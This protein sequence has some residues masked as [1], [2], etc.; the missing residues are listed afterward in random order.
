V[1][2]DKNNIE[3]IQL[4]LQK[5][6]P[7]LLV[8]ET[9]TK[10]T[11]ALQKI[12]KLNPQLVFL[13]IQLGKTNV[14]ELLQKIKLHALEVIFMGEPFPFLS[15]AFHFSGV[16][17]VETPIVR[18]QLKSVVEIV[19]KK[20][21]SK[22]DNDSIFSLLE[23]VQQQ[24]SADTIALPTRQGVKFIKLSQ[25]IYCESIGNYTNFFLVNNQKILVS[26]QLGVC[27]K[28][29]TDD[30]FVRIHHKHLI[31]LSKIKEY[32]NG[33]GGT[34]ILEDATKLIVAARRKA[35]LLSRFEKWSKK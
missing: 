25:I 34:I 18:K 26:R 35:E 32:L 4:L 13:N 33:N 16:G 9:A 14:F 7:Q 2:T 17:Y 20:M 10:A 23:N 28:L 21:E 12:K 1:D 29:L 11:D 22:K 30:N 15:E 3:A 5:N 19:F 8:V 24:Q 31:N 27:E 6:Y